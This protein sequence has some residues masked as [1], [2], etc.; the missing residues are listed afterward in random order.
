MSNISM[1]YHNI[2]S[3]KQNNSY[4]KKIHINS[5][6]FSIFFSCSIVSFSPISSF[7]FPSFTL[8]LPRTTPHC[9][10]ITTHSLITHTHTTHRTQ[11]THKGTPLSFPL[12]FFPFVC[13]GGAVRGMSADY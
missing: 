10:R 4:D 2:P 3:K 13:G 7:P 8:F 5:Y 11:T 12:F 1:A 9:T 6:P